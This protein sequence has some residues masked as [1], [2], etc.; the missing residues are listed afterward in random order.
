M[1]DADE[2]TDEVIG[3]GVGAE[4]TAGDGALDGGYEGDVDERAGAFHE[5][6]G[7]ACD[8]VH[9]GNDEL[10]GGDVVDGEKHPGAE[11]FERWHGGG[12]AL[13]GCGKLFDFA[14]VDGFDEGVA[15]WEVAIEGGVADAGSAC[16]VVEARSCSIAGENFLGYLKDALAV[17]LRVGAGFAG[18]RVWRKLLFLHRNHGGNI[19]QPGIAPA[20]LSIWGLFPFYST[21]TQ[22]SI[23]A[24]SPGS[25]PTAGG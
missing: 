5:P 1:E 18:R 10:F 12:E 19:L 21:E 2:G 15:R 22:M 25:V 11:R 17:A 20:Y 16:D 24:I 14:A 7:A 6:Q 8:G 13:F 23:G 3:V 9:G 4:I